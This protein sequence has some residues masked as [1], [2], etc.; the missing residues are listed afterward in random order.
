M[1]I[2][3]ITQIIY[4]KR[5]K[6]I[7]L[8]KSHKNLYWVPKIQ[9]QRKITIIKTPRHKQHEINK[10]NEPS[11]SWSATPYQQMVTTRC[12]GR[13]PTFIYATRP[14][15]NTCIYE[16]SCVYFLPFSHFF[17]LLVFSI[18]SSFFSDIFFSL[19]SS[20]PSNLCYFLSSFLFNILLTSVF[21][22]FLLNSSV[23]F[24]LPSSYFF[25]LLLTSCFFEA[26][27]FPPKRMPQVHND[28]TRTQR[29][30][31]LLSF[32]R[33]LYPSCSCSKTKWGFSEF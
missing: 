7:L 30:S 4:P 6:N 3:T 26:N 22:A 8:L 17:C 14:S 23:L 16:S 21:S 5:R 11:R 18:L 32:C 13:D 20:F 15:N 2:L 25:H 31:V 28:C 29:D 9:A 1:M 10:R 24:F 19:P 12:H 33:I 27:K